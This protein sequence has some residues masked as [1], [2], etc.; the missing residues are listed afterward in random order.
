MGGLF[1]FVSFGFI[2]SG[3]KQTTPINDKMPTGTKRKA[4]RLVTIDPS[5]LTAIRSTT[6]SNSNSKK[7]KLKPL[8]SHFN[9][10]QKSTRNSQD[11]QKDKQTQTS[12][13]P[14]NPSHANGMLWSDKFTPS[15]PSQLAVHPKKLALI[16]TWL[17][18]ALHGGSHTRKYR[19]LLILAGP[20]GC[21]KSTIIH[22][23]AEPALQTHAPGPSAAASA[24]RSSKSNNSKTV[25]APSVEGIGY[26]ILEWKNTG[27]E[28]S[29]SKPQEFSLWLMRASAGPTL[30]FED[31]EE[32][33][34]DVSLPSTSDQVESDEK[35]RTKLPTLLL[36]DDLPNLS[37][38]ETGRIFTNAIRQHL[39]SPR[40]STPPLVLIVSDT[41]VTP[42]ANGLEESFGGRSG[43]F[44]GAEDRG[45]NVHTL[46]PSDIL[47]HPATCL[48]KLLP[49]NNTLMKK[50]LARIAQSAPTPSFNPGPKHFDLV[51]E[52]SNGDLRAALNNL[53]LF[54]TLP[55]PKMENVGGKSKRN[56]PL[57]DASSLFNR[58]LLSSRDES[59]VIFHSLGKILYNKRWGD[60]AK[61]DAKDKRVRGPKPDPLPAFWAAYNRRQTK[62]DIDRLYSDL[63]VSVDQFVVYLHQNYPPFT[64]TIDEAS[65]FLEYLS[66]SDST[67]SSKD[68]NRYSQAS[69]I[70]FYNFHL[71]ARAILLGLPSPVTRRGQKFFKPALWG[72]LRQVNENAALVDSARD[73]P[74]LLARLR[75]NK[76]QLDEE[77]ND[78]QEGHRHPRDLT[79][80][81]TPSVLNAPKKVLAVEILPFLSMIASSQGHKATSDSMNDELLDRFSTF[82]YPNARDAQVEGLLS[83]D[84]V[85]E[86]DLSPADLPSVNHLPPRPEP[87]LRHNP[88]GIVGQEALQEEEDEML[89]FEEEDDIED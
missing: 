6:T 39:N 67:M 63:S 66:F 7:S 37:H 34:I 72:H 70:S 12:S 20:A 89:W 26:E 73:Q 52:A 14:D 5:Q 31:T 74:G 10:F 71:A 46:L 16:H 42:G 2:Q 54:F 22:T 1:C 57:A 87:P 29:V 44:S 69:M 55:T 82:V 83:E 53:Q 8:E 11:G 78:D 19:R 59:L 40:V 21:G 35:R 23:L 18:D 47:H 27:N 43:G 88:L 68:Q 36:V 60:D 84:D 75:P 15:D 4:P 49:V 9:P 80:G 58:Q 45:M 24:N 3:T 50:L 17:N 32:E 48:L 65:F 76:T 81:P 28:S 86:P 33:S 79:S 85:P 51:V 13:I 41:T 25:S 61:E 64:D 30:S 56:L 77:M 38:S 62:T